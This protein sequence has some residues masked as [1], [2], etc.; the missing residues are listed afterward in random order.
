MSVATLRYLVWNNW[1]HPPLQSPQVDGE[2]LPHLLQEGQIQR[3]ATERVK[4]AEHLTGHGAGGEVT[5]ACEVYD[6]DDDD[7]DDDVDDDD[8]ASLAAARPEWN[9]QC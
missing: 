8:D 9:M 3:D 4:H 7:D 1:D 2:T 5:I 6:D